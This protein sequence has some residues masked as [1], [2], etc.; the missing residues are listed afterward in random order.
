MISFTKKTGPQPTREGSDN[1]F[2]QIRKTAV[3]QHR[4]ADVDAAQKA[5]LQKAKD[6][7]LL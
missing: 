5:E 6:K 4:K 7:N 1:R 2:E 3:T